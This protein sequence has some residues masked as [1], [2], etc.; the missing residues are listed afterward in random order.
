MTEIKITIN[1]TNQYEVEKFAKEQKEK[2][3]SF[4]EWFEKKLYIDNNDSELK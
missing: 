4:D 3:V 1:R 2:F